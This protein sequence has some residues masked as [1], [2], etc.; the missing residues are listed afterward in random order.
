LQ[1][2]LRLNDNKIQR[3]PETIDRR[4]KISKALRLGPLYS[5]YTWVL[6]LQNFRC[7]PGLK[8]LDLGKN[9]LYDVSDLFRLAQCRKIVNLNLGGNT[10]LNA[11]EGYKDRVLAS[12]PQV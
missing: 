3:V 12:C 11:I 2:E 5:K 1:E 8:V 6:T 9:R 10:K 4:Q 7:S